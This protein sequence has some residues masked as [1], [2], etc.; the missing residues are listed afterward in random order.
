ML[1]KVLLF[2]AH[3]DPGRIDFLRPGLL[4]TRLP[5]R[6][7]VPRP[8]SRICRCSRLHYT[9]V[10]TSDCAPRTTIAHVSPSEQLIPM[11]GLTALEHTVKPETTLEKI[12][13]LVEYGFTHTHRLTAFI[14]ACA[15]GSLVVLRMLKVSLCRY[16]WVARVP[17]VLFVVIISTSTFFVFS[18]RPLRLSVNSSIG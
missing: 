12:L 13:F 11:L 17:E 4:P 3:V 16:K 5:R 7:P 10:S 1:S 9:H 2:F 18:L 14:S 15:L 6:C 8:P